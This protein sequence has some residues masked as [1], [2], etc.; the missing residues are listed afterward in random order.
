MSS[1]NTAKKAKEAEAAKKAEA[2]KDN[3]PKPKKGDI[4]PYSKVITKDAKR[5]LGLFTVHNIDGAFFYE[6]PDSLLIEKC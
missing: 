4:Q 3:T 1:C 5:D 6:I 2:A